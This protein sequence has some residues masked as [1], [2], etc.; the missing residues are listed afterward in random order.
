MSVRFRPSVPTTVV[1]DASS[2][3][4]IKHLRPLA[5]LNAR[6][7]AV[8]F[9]YRPVIFRYKSGTKGMM[10]RGARIAR[11]SKSGYREIGRANGQ[12]RPGT[13]SQSGGHEGLLLGR[14]GRRVL[15]QLGPLCG[16]EQ[17]LGRNSCRTAAFQY[18]ERVLSTP[19][20]RSQLCV[21]VSRRTSRP[22][23]ISNQAL[24]RTL[25]SYRACKSSMSAS[26]AWNRQILECWS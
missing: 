21:V 8:I 20:Y 7:R 25:H 12:L 1:G 24:A 22:C 6:C 10:P 2:P 16:L 5:I 23:G 19:M 3:Y 11:L 13:V 18:G 14:S 4:R 17:S 9:R 15:N 26:G